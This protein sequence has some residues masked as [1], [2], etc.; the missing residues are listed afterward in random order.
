M[1]LLRPHFQLQVR[2]PNVD[3]SLHKN[4][5]PLKYVERVAREK[6][7][8]LQPNLQKKERLLTA[9]TTVHLGRKILAKPED[10]K[11]AE[12]MLR[13]LSGSLHLVTTAVCYGSASSIKS[14][15]VTTKVWFRKLKKEELDD[16]LYSGD[17]EGKAGAYGIQG[18]ASFFVERIHGSL[19]NV[20]GLPL[21]SVLKRLIG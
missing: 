11:D 8:S 5:A 2:V 13:F 15:R 17:W 12:R 7:L 4:E 18:Q 6:F 14:F 9:D 3:E 20:I 21:E 1:E 10:R 19:T 16:Y